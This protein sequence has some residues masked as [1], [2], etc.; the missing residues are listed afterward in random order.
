MCSATR[1]LL[2]RCYWRCSLVIRMR[3]TRF[4]FITSGEGYLSG[5]FLTF[6]QYL[7]NRF[8]KSLTVITILDPF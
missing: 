3:L 4:T 8:N 7:Q 6:I 2:K 1:S 5:S